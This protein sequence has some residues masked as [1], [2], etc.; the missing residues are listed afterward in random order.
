MEYAGVALT[1]PCS[2]R[3]MNKIN[4]LA[5]YR[6]F[7][8]TTLALYRPFIFTT[9]ALYRP[10]I[11]TTLA[12]YLPYIFTTLVLYRALYFEVAWLEGLIYGPG[13]WWYMYSVNACIK[14]RQLWCRAV[15][16]HSLLTMIFTL[17]QTVL[18]CIMYHWIAIDNAIL[19]YKQIYLGMP[20][21]FSWKVGNQKKHFLTYIFLTGIFQLIIKWEAQDFEYP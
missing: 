13:C 15:W 11:F 3:Y 2:I 14:D 9:L 10:Y 20:G 1:F 17:S 12:L 21:L 7:I 4:T 8:F 18:I 16:R 6:P 5:L 19:W